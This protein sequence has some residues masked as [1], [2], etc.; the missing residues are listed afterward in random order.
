MV[1]VAIELQEKY[2]THYLEFPLETCSFGPNENSMWDRSKIALDE[3]SEN[4]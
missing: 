3:N 4:E 1:K 2:L